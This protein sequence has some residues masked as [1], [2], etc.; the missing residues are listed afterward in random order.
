MVT[1]ALFTKL[2]KKR[3]KTQHSSINEWI[4][5]RQC[6][7][8]MEYNLAIKRNQVLTDSITC[9]SLEKLGSGQE[10]RHERPHI[11]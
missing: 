9:M 8:T 11:A 4:N 3:K 1:E 5:Q 6:I 2:K 7:Y 10:R